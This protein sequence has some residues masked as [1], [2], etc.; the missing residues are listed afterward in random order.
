LVKDL[1]N[2]KILAGI[3]EDEAAKLR[4]LRLPPAGAR[5]DDQSE[6]QAMAPSHAEDDDPEP[7]EKGSD[8]VERR[9]EK[10]MSELRDR[11][12]V[13]VND[14]KAYEE[15]KVGPKYLPYSRIMSTNL[16]LFCSVLQTLISLDLYIAYLRAAFNACYYCSVV[17]DHLEE[18]QR[19]C[20][21][22]ARKP[23]SQSLLDEVKAEAEKAEKE[24]KDKD[25]EMEDVETVEK[26]K[27]KDVKKEGQW[28]D[29]NENRDWKRNGLCPVMRIMMAF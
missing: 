14:E 20:L 4:Q 21:K 1:A 7:K 18:L 3:L 22:H 13:D 11:N 28:R 2:A 12:L 23:L 10:V 9:I 16:N 15:K 27:E 6:D 19:K 8:A 17:T 29:R 5:V 25:E 26:E 24:K